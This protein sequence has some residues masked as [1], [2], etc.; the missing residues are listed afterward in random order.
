MARVRKCK[1]PGDM[2]GFLLPGRRTKTAVHRAQHAVSG[3]PGSIE[4]TNGILT[5]SDGNT[6]DLGS[7][8]SQI[9]RHA[10]DK[11]LSQGKSLL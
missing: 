9:T 3:N 11:I 6:F 8:R 1:K 10:C 7:L 2:P 5:G 4:G